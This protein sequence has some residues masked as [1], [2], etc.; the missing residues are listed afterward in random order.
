MRRLL[1]LILTFVSF[2]AFSCSEPS[3]ESSDVSS[4]KGKKDLLS[5]EAVE[6]LINFQNL[7]RVNIVNGKIIEIESLET[8]AEK[9]NAWFDKGGLKASG[10]QREYYLYWV[11][12]FRGMK[13]AQP[14]LFHAINIGQSIVEAVAIIPEILDVLIECSGSQENFSKQTSLSLSKFDPNSSSSVEPTLDENLFGE[15]QVNSSLDSYVKIEDLLEYNFKATSTA[16]QGGGSTASL[17]WCIMLTC[18]DAHETG[19]LDSNKGCIGMSQT[20]TES[21]D[22]LGWPYYPKVDNLEGGDLSDSL[23]IDSSMCNSEPN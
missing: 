11:S 5:K 12:C 6:K 20:D 3:S 18:E 17:S 2:V 21:A 19:A 10:K 13:Y 23:K 15:G 8:V 16:G 7:T 4:N 14:G 9:H 1:T 22:R